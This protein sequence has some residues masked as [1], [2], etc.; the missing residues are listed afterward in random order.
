[1]NKQGFTIIELLVVISIIS[2][3]SL[4]GVISLNRTRE[5]AQDTKRIG[6]TRQ[7]R[8]ALDLFFDYNN[9]YPITTV[10]CDSTDLDNV[11][12]SQ[13]GITGF[14]ELMV[15]LM[16][17]GNELIGI[18]PKDPKN[19]GKYFYR[20]CSINDVYEI[21]YYSQIEDRFITHKAY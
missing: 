17:S 15:Q 7:I 1:M 2:I 12:A 5:D 13:N 19:S 14:D 11:S 18:K 9:Y 21:S 16:D 20:Y 10:D 4:I 3:I 6:D 8:I